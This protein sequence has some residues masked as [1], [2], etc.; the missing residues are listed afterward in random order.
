MPTIQS[1]KVCTRSFEN[2]K[3]RNLKNKISLSNIQLVKFKIIL[4][5]VVMAERLVAFEKATTK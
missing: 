3:K 1:N 4:N 5:G 2:I